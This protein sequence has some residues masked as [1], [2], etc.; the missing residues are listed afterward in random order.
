MRLYRMKFLCSLFL[1]IPF[2][3]FSQS[4]F[5]SKLPCSPTTDCTIYGTVE[6]NG[7]PL[8]NVIVSDGYEITKTDKQGRYF[9]VSQKRNGYVF[10]TAPGNYAYEVKDALPQLWAN[11]NNSK[12]IAERHDFRLVKASHKKFA[13]IALTDIHMANYYDAPQH[14]RNKDVPV[15]RNTVNGLL[16]KHGKKYKVYTINGGDSSYDTYWVTGSYTIRDFPATLKETQYPTPMFNVMGNHDNDP[17]ELAGKDVDFRAEQAYRDALGPTY[18]SFNIGKIHF[19]VLDNII[20]N[21]KPG[22]GFESMGLPGMIDYT[23]GITPNQMEWLRKDLALQPHDAPLVV[24]MHDPLFLRK[25]LSLTEYKH[26]FDDPS[27]AKELIRLISTFPETH[28]IDGHSHRNYTFHCDS[29]RIIDHN[30]S[31]ICGNWWRTGFTGY[32]T[33]TISRT[34]KGEK[35]FHK[36]HDQINPDG[37]PSGYYVFNVDGRKITWRYQSLSDPADVQF[38]AWDMNEVRRYSQNSSDY[39]D[40]INAYYKRCDYRQLP[41]NQV[42]IN[43][44]AFDSKW[45]IRVWEDGKEIPA[46]L[47]LLE[48][49]EYTYWYNFF[50]AVDNGRFDSPSYQKVKYGVSFRVQ[51]S[52]PTSTLRIEATDSFGNKYTKIMTRPQ[53]FDPGR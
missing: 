18:Y 33:Y 47:D 26:N 44:W 11:L 49:P 31:S 21:N 37:T 7:K 14:F 8:S 38:R 4:V 5:Q 15:I 12:G 3:G 24:C 13:F 53:K 48:S 35:V 36:G 20:Y 9:L 30:V 42:W 52:S 19:V 22:K 6:C 27:N 32:D 10:V 43:V 16:K 29:L 39:A 17:F 51:C 2:I 50:M 34:K 41:D 46:K 40:F 25:K 28:I 1:S 45:K 23:V